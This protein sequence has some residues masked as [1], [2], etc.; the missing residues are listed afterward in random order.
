MNQLSEINAVLNQARE[1]E[2]EG[3]LKKAVRL[4]QAN[5]DRNDITTERRI[6]I[7]NLAGKLLAD[8]TSYKEAIKMYKKA[9]KHGKE[10]G[11]NYG[12]GIANAQHALM[13]A[14]TGNLEE[15]IQLLNKAEREFKLTSG[16][17]Y[18]YGEATLLSIRAFTDFVSGNLVEA[19]K[20][21]LHALSMWS[22][23]GDVEE[24]L[25]VANMIGRIHYLQ[26]EY[27]E[28]L[29]Q[30]KA[31]AKTAEQHGYK[32]RAAICYNN[33]GVV[34]AR[35]GEYQ[36]A[37]DNYTRYRDLSIEYATMEGL[38]VAYYN[39]GSLHVTIGN[40]EQALKNFQAAEEIYSTNWDVTGLRLAVSGLAECYYYLGDKLKARELYELSLEYFEQ[41][42]FE[43][44]MVETLSKYITLL[45]D[46]NEIQRAYEYLEKMRFLA[47]KHESKIDNIYYIYQKACIEYAQENTGTAR[48]ILEIVI[49]KAEESNLF[50]IASQSRIRLARIY[51]DSYSHNI[52]SDRIILDKAEQLLKDAAASCEKHHVFPL[53]VDILLIQAAFSLKKALDDKAFNEARETLQ[54][55]RT[56]CRVKNFKALELKVKALEDQLTRKRKLMTFISDEK[57]KTAY[58]TL[59]QEE[60]SFFIDSALKRGIDRSIKHD[61]IYFIIYSLKNGITRP[62]YSDL[63]DTELETIPDLR[64]FHGQTGVYFSYAIYQGKF[65]R[66]ITG[67][68]GPLPV[69]DMKDFFALIYSASWGESEGKEIDES[70]L[71]SL[72]VPKRILAR[73]YD[74]ERLEATFKAFLEHTSPDNYL[75]SIKELK[76]RLI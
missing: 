64:S 44:L 48:E 17:Q 34:S 46:L 65:D 58:K 47:I 2:K 57:V 12:Q 71:F 59:A 13:I 53:L 7:M 21:L 24:Q 60:V 62:F 74:R 14:G 32:R 43:E 56:I 22:L 76:R 37:L 69:S 27:R 63:L 23:I 52:S 10:C 66:K 36:Q 29:Q 70:Y 1:L 11:Y 9:V 4:L 33:I 68:Y 41:S 5:L 15:A 75:S 30:W 18:R 20:K 61:D 31:T 25:W 35:T 40:Y 19:Q 6:D 39:I 16:E 73:M 45:I 8:L 3:Q 72:L 28:A 55:A 51:F 42:G 49:E 38:G 67:L 50:E 26:G 54:L